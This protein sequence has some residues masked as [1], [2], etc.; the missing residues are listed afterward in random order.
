ME[1]A[2]GLIENVLRFRGADGSGWIYDLSD[3]VDG[4]SRQW[5]LTLGDPFPY[6]TINFVA[7]ATRSDGSECALKVGFLLDELADEMRALGAYD[8]RGAVRLLECRP[9]QGAMLLERA[10]PG[11]GLDEE[12]DDERACEIGA[13]CMLGLWRPAASAPGARTVADWALGLGRMR[14]HLR[15]T[16]GPVPPDAVTLA[17]AVFERLNGDDDPVLLHGDL[18]HFNIV[19]AGRAPWLALDPKGV[20][21]SRAYEVGP[22]IANRFDGSPD[23]QR[24]LRVC[25]DCLSRALGLDRALLAECTLAHAVLS[26]WWGFEDN[27]EW[28]AD[29]LGYI[30]RTFEA[31]RAA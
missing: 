22:F 12:A 24:S 29:G 10:R 28:S 13:A 1:V 31:A 6:S 23:P 4:L 9:E 19:R 2:P 7:P 25:L 16:P 21:G 30:E 20:T 27:G 11:T 17:E 15:D 26:A 5:G 3:L 18:H 8:G 14:R